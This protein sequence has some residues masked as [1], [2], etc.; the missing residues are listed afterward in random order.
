MIEAHNIRYFSMLVGTTVRTP[1]TRFIKKRQAWVR[2][3]CHRRPKTIDNDL[4]TDHTPGYGSVIKYNATTVMEVG[5]DVSSM[6][7]DEDP[8]A[9]S[10]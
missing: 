2:Y 7:T 9:S 6:A 1:P 3:P 5:A 10:R 4:H 8:A